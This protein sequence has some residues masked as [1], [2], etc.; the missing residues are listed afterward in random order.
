MNQ[1]K[2]SFPAIPGVGSPLSNDMFH[3]SVDN[4][5]TRNCV[6]NFINSFTVICLTRYRS[7]CNRGKFTV[8]YTYL[9]ITH[10]FQQSL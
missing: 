10:L 1:N 6:V 4:I 7:F 3:L 5:T 8:H 9:D 2:I